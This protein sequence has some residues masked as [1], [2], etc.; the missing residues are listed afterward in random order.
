MFYF[1]AMPRKKPTAHF[2]EQFQR[3]LTANRDAIAF[4]RKN[5]LWEGLLQYGWVSKLMVVLGFVVSLKFYQIFSNW[6]SRSDATDNPVVMIQNMGGLISDV[7]TE[8][9]DLFFMSGFK[10]LLLILLEIFIFHLARRTLEIKTGNKIDCTFNT[11]VQAEIRMIKVAI[12]CFILETIIVFV[13]SMGANVLGIEI[14]KPL[15]AIAVQC[16]FL[17]FLVV[18]NYNEIYGMS[19]KESDHFSRQYAGLLLSIGLGAY[20]MLSIPLIGAICAPF[21]SAVGATL[22]MHEYVGQAG[23][24]QFSMESSTELV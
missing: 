1:V 15:I 18:D 22:V 4:I 7:A 10:Y 24:E 16:Y 5:K 12:R 17:G 23:P 8:G 14:L 11:F 3:G 20:V 21:I 2:L 9:Y 6:L 13:L 19:I